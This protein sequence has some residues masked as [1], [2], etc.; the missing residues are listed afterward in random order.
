VFGSQAITE[1]FA[2]LLNITSITLPSERSVLVDPVYLTKLTVRLQNPTWVT[3]QFGTL[4]PS[5]SQSTQFPLSVWLHL[6]RGAGHE[7]R[8]G[9]QLK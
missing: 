4:P 8:R 7:K 6:F 9:E 1:G 3:P 2:Q 5:P